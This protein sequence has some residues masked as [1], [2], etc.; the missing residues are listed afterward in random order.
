[1]TQ[2]K[3]QSLKS[4]HAHT[5]SPVTGLLV[6]HIVRTIFDVRCQVIML[7]CVFELHACMHDESDAA[8][9]H[10]FIFHIYK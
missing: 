6:S 3:L 5:Y 7:A 10:D 1:M 4:A 8:S 9:D 2:H